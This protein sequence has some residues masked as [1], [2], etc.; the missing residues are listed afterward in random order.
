MKILFLCPN[1]VY[2]NVLMH[3][4]SADKD[5][6]VKYDGRDFNFANANI[7]SYDIFIMIDS[8]LK[9]I[10]KTQGEDVLPQCKLQNKHTK[11]VLM[12]MNPLP[13]AQTAAQYAEIFDCI[14]TVDW[15]DA[16]RYGFLYVHQIY[17]TL[18][19]RSK[20]GYKS[21]I[22]FIGREKGRDSII[23]A[24]YN[25]ALKNGLRPD[26][27]VYHGKNNRR[28]NKGAWMSYHD[29]LRRT[30]Q[31]RCVLEILQTKQQGYTLRS[32][33]A[34]AYNRLLI[35]NNTLITSNPYYSDR[36]MSVF[37][38]KPFIDMKMFEVGNRPAYNYAHD[39]SPKRLI[40]MIIEYLFDK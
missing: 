7:S 16:Q 38:D 17:S 32:I 6:T 20:I 13:D 40:Q 3:D 30:L 4:I 31:S 10:R 8:H 27:S 18:T 37:T 29:V 19:Q 1:I 14:T 26:F 12:C 5:I 23:N 24:F 34:I 25:L 33:E 11:F 28:Y 9:P 15:G 35:T 39:Y 2:Y 22:C 36:T 21:D